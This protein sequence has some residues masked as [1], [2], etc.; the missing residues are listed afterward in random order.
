MHAECSDQ[1]S[2]AGSQTCYTVL[3]DKHTAHSRQKLHSMLEEHTQYQHQ[4]KAL[5][6]GV[7]RLHDPEGLCLQDNNSSRAGAVNTNRR[8]SD[9]AAEPAIQTGLR[10]IPR[11]LQ[12]RYH[13]ASKVACCCA[14]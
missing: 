7:P 5:L 3:L 12:Y 2:C 6:S 9:D 13:S 14:K 1:G 4:S 10:S 11:P 8:D